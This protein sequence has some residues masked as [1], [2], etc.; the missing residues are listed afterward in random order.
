MKNRFIRIMRYRLL[1]QSSN[2]YGVLIILRLQESGLVVQ[3]PPGMGKTYTIANSIRLM[4][5]NCKRVL[6]VSH[7]ELG[8][9]VIRDQRPVGVR[10]QP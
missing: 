6:V 10:D 3:G 2:H 7:G 8:L 4:R 5:A 9:G 1:P